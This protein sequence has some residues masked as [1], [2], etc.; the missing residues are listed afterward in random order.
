MKITLREMRALVKMLEHE[1]F[2]YGDEGQE[3]Q[4]AFKKIS[5]SADA[6]MA[7]VALE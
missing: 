4:S 1:H 7:L 2:S 6:G 5:D 3:A